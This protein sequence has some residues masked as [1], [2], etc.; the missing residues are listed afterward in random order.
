[1]NFE[2]QKWLQRAFQVKPYFFSLLFILYIWLIQPILMRLLAASQDGS[3]NIWLGWGLLF[4]PL[5]EFAGIFSKLPVSNYFHSQKNEDRT[6][7]NA[8]VFL[9]II[10]MVLHLGLGCLYMFV[11]FQIIQG[12]PL[13]NGSTFYIVL[14]IVLMFVVIAKEAFIIVVIMS[15]T[16]LPGA[17]LPA[18]NKFDQW[19]FAKVNQNTIRFLSWDNFILDMAGDGFLFIFSAISFT[20]MWNFIVSLNPPDMIWPKAISELLGVLSYFMMIY[21]PL[22][23]SSFPFEMNIIQSKKQWIIYIGSILFAALMSILPFLI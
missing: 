15:A 16:P 14:S 9:F 18:N 7:V 6:N 23:A 20:V 4:I 19:L 13:N 3:G 5:L 8:V 21:L 17:N 12:V 11:C 22:R 2:N 10:D 1:M